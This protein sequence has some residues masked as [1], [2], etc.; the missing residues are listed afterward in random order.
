MNEQNIIP[1][2][3]PSGKKPIYK[4]RGI[5]AVLSLLLALLVLLNVAAT[6]LVLFSDEQGD[7]TTAVSGS[8]SY[9]DA[10][11]KDYLAAFGPSLFTGK[12][13]AGKEYAIDAVTDAYIIRSINAEIL[14]L[15]AY[16]NNGRLNKTAPIDYADE[17]VLYILGVKEVGEDGVTLK[18]VDESLFVNAYGQS[19]TLT[20]G[21]EL[22]GKAFD[23]ALIGKTPLELGSVIFRDHGY[24]SDG[25]ETVFVVSYEARKDGESAVFKTASNLRVDTAAP[26]GALA[27]AIAAKLSSTSMPLGD[28][29]KLDISHDADDDGKDE[30]V[31]YTVWVDTAATE[32]PAEVRVALPEDYFGENDEAYTLNGKTLCF[33]IFVNYSIAKDV[34]YKETDGTMKAIEG[35]ETL[36]ATFIKKALASYT[37]S[38]GAQGIG[39]GF[40]TTETDD[41]AVRAAYFAFVKKNI[42]ESLV[43]MRKQNA[44]SLIWQ[45]LLDEISFDSL[46][47]DVV[48]SL[49]ENTVANILSAYNQNLYQYQSS[50]SSIYPTVEDFAR[51]ELGYAKEDYENYQAYVQKEIAEKEVKYQLLIYAI[52]NSGAIENAYGKYMKLLNEYVDAVIKSAEESKKLT[53]TRDEALESLY[54][55]DVKN[56]ID[57]KHSIILQVVNDFLYEQNTIDWELSAEN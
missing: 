28:S 55:L 49:K 45:G 25:G 4:K 15:A 7:G 6:L 57:T 36:T 32:A 2:A 54:V 8:F 3:S 50:F 48:K 11:I 13:F 9:A 16:T 56:G 26:N 14:A 40:T 19:T 53:I 41:A 5:F 39:Y 20:I 21:K 47:E 35:Y 29:F 52:Y 51:A 46:P 17:V 38:D 30:L 33:T 31:H 18:D 1:E 37:T 23:E 43:S 27:E 22:L 34:T 42:E 12:T 44:V 24:T 10:D